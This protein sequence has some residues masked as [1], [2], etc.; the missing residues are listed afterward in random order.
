MA[1]AAGARPD[2]PKKASHPCLAASR[3]V[4][5]SPAAGRVGC[6]SCWPLL[7][8]RRGSASCVK[9]V[10]GVA[11]VGGCQGQNLQASLAL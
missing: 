2:H 5:W 3:S 4:L 11:I 8:W 6:G 7:A 9:A 10:A 1:L